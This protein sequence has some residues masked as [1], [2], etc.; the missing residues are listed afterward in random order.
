VRYVPCGG[1]RILRNI[2]RGLIPSG[3]WIRCSCGSCWGWCENRFVGTSERCLVCSARLWWLV[4]VSMSMG[5]L[6]RSNCL[7]DT[8]SREIPIHCS[9]VTFITDMAAGEHHTVLIITYMS[10][11]LSLESLL[12]GSRS[13]NMTRLMNP[14]GPIVPPTKRTNS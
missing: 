10:S 7:V 14:P 8:N 13:R 6:R 3:L 4:S 11:D 1:R 9:V 12:R 2:R 5:L